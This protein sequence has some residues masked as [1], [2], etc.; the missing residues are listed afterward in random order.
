M[1]FN[2]AIL[3]LSNKVGDGSTEQFIVYRDMHGGW[4]C[5]YTQNQYGETYDWVDDAT[6]H[7]P[8]ALLFSAADF[9]SDSISDSYNTVL[10]SRIRL[11][12]VIGNLFSNDKENHGALANFFSDNVGAFSREATDYLTTLERPLA[13]LAEMCPFDMATDHEDWKY[14]E[15]IAAD[16]IGRIENAV[17]DRLHIHMDK[18]EIERQAPGE[19]KE[20]AKIN[21]NDSDIILAEN[22]EAEHRYIVIEN[23]FTEYY[24]NQG[25]N[26]IFKGHTNDYIEAIDEFTQR[27]QY[28]NNCVQSR[29]DCLRR[30]DGV[31]YAEL[32]SS[33]CLPGSGG[34]DFTGELIIIKAGELRPEYRTADSQLV[35]CSH[36]NGARPNAKGTS[37]FGEELFSGDKVR[38]GRHQ[39]QGIADE[40]KLP[41]WAKEE[42]A[43]LNKM[44][45]HGVNEQLQCNES[46]QNSTPAKKPTL[47]EKLDF[48]KKKI[49][50]HDAARKDSRNVKPRI[51]DGRE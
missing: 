32:N 21:I 41:Q 46:P 49:A 20:L 22:P 47:Q 33:D 48:A 43:L 16:A 29:R 9:Q 45:E 3:S 6:E 31:E 19:Y 18:P 1:N 30:S 36:G 24:N 2:S 40:S 23:R 8:F 13:A 34:A 37:V 35:V 5:D 15:D 14:N 42:L 27:V 12:S 17:R 38:Y 25:N 11:E 26:C 51:H 4:H 28:N 7:D 50:I 39:V 10:G 44:K